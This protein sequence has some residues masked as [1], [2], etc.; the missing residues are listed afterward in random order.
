MDKAELKK[1]LVGILG[2]EGVKDDAATLEEFSHDMTEIEGAMPSFVVAATTAEQ[3]QGLM[4]LANE[5]R[6]G[7]TPRVA[8]TN[9]G[10]L[11]LP[12]EGGIVLDLRKMNK[13]HEVN[14]VEMYAV[15]EP[16]TSF[17]DM[18][19]YL[20][21]HNPELRIGYPLAP[22]EV[23]VVCNCL[24][25]GLGNLSIRGGAMDEWINGLEVVL[26]SGAMART[27]SMAISDVAY[28]RAPLPDVTGLF[29]GFQGTTG[30]VTR[31]SIELYPE[32]P[33][34]WR[35]FILNYSFEGTYDVIRRLARMD[36]CDDM[37]GL[38]WPTGKMMFGVE[39]PG[40]RD[41]DEPEFFLYLDISGVTEEHLQWKMSLVDQ[42]VGEMRA[43]GHRLEEP[44]GITDLIKLNPA[45][46]SFAEFPT[47]LGFLLDHAGGGLTW[48]GLYGPMSKWD[49]AS[50]EGE[51]IMGRYGFPPALVSRPMKGGHFCVLRF[52]ETFDRKDPDEVQR[53]RDCHKE[54]VQMAIGH[55]YVPYKTPQ[56]IVGSAFKEQMD[57]GFLGLVRGVKRLLDPNQVMNPGKWETE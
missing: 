17:A 33:Y 21:E 28:G 49:V 42:A 14:P 24:C 4:R 45:F 2:E 29:I 27:G 23:S 48:V 12:A 15:I 6:V 16:G 8:G 35:G 52:I 43:Q 9:L 36:I 34:R 54:L 53:V 1:R 41:P 55:G 31:A 30:V 5:A 44:L 37:G 25:Q 13:I 22:P 50:R 11:S 10:G 51:K 47:R 20:D 57:P 32:N 19:A 3:V 46:E 39:R 26:P 7:V 56:W 40:E 38:S 18:R